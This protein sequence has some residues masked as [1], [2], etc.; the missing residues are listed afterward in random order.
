MRYSI[1]AFASVVALTGCGGDDAASPSGSGPS[2]PAS[3]STPAEPPVALTGT[4]NDHGLG[5]ATSGTL[6]VELDDSYFKPTYIKGT[7]GASVTLNLTNG[8]ALPHT[9]TVDAPKVDVTVP[10]GGTGKAAF[11]LP[12]SGALAFYCKFHQQGG[13]QGAIYFKAG[14]TVAS[15]ASGDT[16]YGYGK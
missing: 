13:M 8:G 3:S 16:G 12:A 4:V 11:T 14:D 6:D 2:S 1:V 10:A 9:F 5:D 15:G 7:P